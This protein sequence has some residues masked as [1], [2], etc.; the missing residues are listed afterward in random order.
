MITV[1][2]E[3]SFGLF[4]A[5][6]VKFC[7]TITEEGVPDFHKT[8]KGHDNL[9]GLSYDDYERMVNGEPLEEVISRWK[10]SL[11]KGVQ[12]LENNMSKNSIRL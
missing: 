3:L 7:M 2:V 6:K 12:I 1:R 8:F 10:R 11:D 4:V 5:N 9:T